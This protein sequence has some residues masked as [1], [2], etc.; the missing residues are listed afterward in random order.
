MKKLF[1]LLFVLLQF[2]SVS[3]R[4][5]EGMW[6]MH[7]LEKQN[8]H[9]MQERGLKLTPEQIYSVNNSSLK[10]AIIQFGRGCTGEI[11]SNKGL[12]LTNHHCGYGQIQ[13]HSTVENDI[14]KN[15]FW[16]Q[17]LHEELPNPGLTARFLVRIEDVTA[18]ILAELNNNMTEEERANKIREISTKLEKEAIEGTHY[19]AQVSNFYAGNEFILFVYE[20][21]RDV[22]LV[23]TPPSSIGK[24]GADTDNWMWPR[25]TGDFALFRVYMSPEGKPADFSKEN[26][27]YVPKHYLPISIKGIQENDFAMTIGYPGRTSRY[28]TSWGITQAIE[29]SNPTIVKTRDLKLKIMREDM[30]NNPAVRIQYASKYA[31]IANGWKYFIGQTRGLKRL[32][33]YDRKVEIEREFQTWANSTPE[34]MKV[35]GNVL[36]D[37]ERAYKMQENY[38]LSRWYYIETLV[39]GAEIIGF[40][41]RMEDLLVELEKKDKDQAKIDRL[42]K[43][44]KKSV[45]DT[46]KDINID[47]DKRLFHNMLQMFVTSVPKNLQPKMLV[48]INDKYKGNFE[49]YAEKVYS[50]SI[51]ADTNKLMKFLKAPNARTLQRDPIF[52]LQQDIFKSYFE[53]LAKMQ[54]SNDILSRA[55]RLFI[56]GLREMHSDRVFYPDANSTMRLSYG[57]ILDYIPADAV[58]FNYFTTTNGIIEKEDPN[59]W[60]FEVPERLKELILNKD[61]GRYA[62]DGVM[63]VNFISNN[64]ITGGNSG[65]PVLNA[66][67]HLIG[68]A[69][70]GNWEAMSGDIFFEPEVQRTISVDARYILFIIDK[71]AGA[72]HLIDEMTII[73]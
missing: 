31:Q 13:S 29:Q 19:T 17:S 57:Q 45:R 18:K 26:I 69:F 21:F 71:F 8:F 30:D 28:L 73:E 11:I 22:R 12:V 66:Y 58:H 37:F 56:A 62:Q 72:K 23:G 52:V 41:R 38:N 25:H 36:S 55:N 53:L 33:V 44:L 9:K 59:N 61:F 50:R 39:R 42:V 47:T 65:S 40:S 60:E 68:L 32:N 43:N 67:G 64:D 51:F 70:D 4:A 35:Y 27:P 16:A 7:I 34:N 63:Y 1:L 46:Y 14:L 48:E 6:L 2:V 20:I 24:F 49:R 15:G 5:D 54:E 3:T 10:D